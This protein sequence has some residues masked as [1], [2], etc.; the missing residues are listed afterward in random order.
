MEASSSKA[1]EQLKVLAAR[2]GPKSVLPLSKLTHYNSDLPC[3]Y[4]NQQRSLRTRMLGQKEVRARK[5]K[6]RNRN[7]GTDWK[8]ANQIIFR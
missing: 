2:G 8:R 4:Q 5:L 3:S 1:Q 7:W 6:H